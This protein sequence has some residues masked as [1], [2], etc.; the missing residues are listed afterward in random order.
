MK[1]LSRRYLKQY[2]IKLPPKNA[3]YE[4]RY[5]DRYSVEIYNKKTGITEKHDARSY[6]MHTMHYD[7]EVYNYPDYVIAQVMAIIT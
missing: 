4:V 3:I 5:N 7:E 2:G 1:T 6:V